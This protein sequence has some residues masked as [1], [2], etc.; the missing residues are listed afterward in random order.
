MITKLSN[1]HL[2]WFQLWKQTFNLYT[3][4]NLAL[5]NVVNRSFPP[6]IGCSSPPRLQEKL[7][8]KPWTI[9]QYIAKLKQKLKLQL[10]LISEFPDPSLVELS[11]PL[12]LSFTTA[13]SFWGDVFTT[14]Q[15]ICFIIF[16]IGPIRAK[17]MSQSSSVIGL[18]P[19][20]KLLYSGV[21][22]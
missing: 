2:N 18:K 5:S 13:P 11:K 19:E 21:K 8:Q 14:W 4:L 3:D 22:T 1:N 16:S 9:K 15:F 7:K 6:P 10:G 12:S 20:A 17:Q